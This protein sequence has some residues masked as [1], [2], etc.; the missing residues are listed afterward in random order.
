MYMA[1]S[2]WEAER[3]LQAQRRQL[4][5]PTQAPHLPRKSVL[6]LYLLFWNKKSR[7][8]HLTPK[9]V[10]PF[11]TTFEGWN[12]DWWDGSKPPFWDLMLPTLSPC[13]LPSVGGKGC[14]GDRVPVSL[15]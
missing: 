12:K 7:L 8:L 6:E 9:S 15:P 5:T 11:C 3:G 1:I 4:P 14:T 13:S 2:G 10:L